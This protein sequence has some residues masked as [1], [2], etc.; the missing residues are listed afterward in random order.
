[1]FRAA[2]RSPPGPQVSPAEVPRLLSTVGALSVYLPLLDRELWGLGAV[3]ILL[4]TVPAQQGR[5]CTQLA[6]VLG[7]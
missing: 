4:T 1:M 3:S 2:P 6:E 5:S 7:E